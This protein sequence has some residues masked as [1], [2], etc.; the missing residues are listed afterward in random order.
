MKG[1]LHYI[2][3][4]MLHHELLAESLLSHEDY[5][6]EIEMCGQSH[7][8]EDSEIDHE[9]HIEAVNNANVGWTAGPNT[10]FT[11]RKLSDIKSWMGTIVDP[12][13][14]I[15][16]PKADPYESPLDTVPTDFDCR[17]MH[18]NCPEMAKVRD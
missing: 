18:T 13:W 17:T 2:E 10:R 16:A 7:L 8:L 6:V 9:A 1:A 3:N 14:V 5:C 12:D 11:G 4:K 15:S